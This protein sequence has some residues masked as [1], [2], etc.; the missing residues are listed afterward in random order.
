VKEGSLLSFLNFSCALDPFLIVY[1]YSA[2][3]VIMF[4]CT[5]TTGMADW[6]FEMG[7]ALLSC[8]GM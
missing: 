3:I 6:C 2:R 7:W 4:P 1:G 5:E 8:P